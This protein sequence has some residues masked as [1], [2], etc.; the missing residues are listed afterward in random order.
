M[1][2]KYE[3]VIKY[4]LDNYVNGAPALNGVIP[5][6]PALAKE[7][8]M[9][10]CPVNQAINKLVDRGIL[11]KISGVGTFTK[12]YAPRKYGTKKHENMVGTTSFIE[13]F[14]SEILKSLQ[15]KL[16]PE[17]IIINN[18]FDDKNKLESLVQTYTSMKCRG[19]FI[20]PE[21]DFTDNMKRTKVLANRLANKGIIP[22]LV[23]RSVPDYDGVQV[24]VDNTGGTAMAVEYM[25]RSG[26]NKVAYI[27]KD[28]YTVGHDRFKGYLNAL[29]TNNITPD[30]SMIYNDK[31]GINFLENYEKMV[32]DGMTQITKKHPECKCF[33]AFNMA[34][35]FK[36]FLFLKEKDLFDEKI[37]IAG[38]DNFPISPSAEF[39][40]CYIELERPLE[41]IGRVAAS[42]FLEI[43]SLKGNNRLHWI[44]KRILPAMH[45][46]LLN[47]NGFAAKNMRMF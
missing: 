46:P 1:K 31:S 28:D 36:I 14:P 24:T 45:L 15:L 20:I 22:I 16:A 10:R 4:V 40:R 27:G 18:L 38:F 23:E 32:Y 2:Y 8:G 39:E 33:M 43:E 6:E 3:I 41:E 42:T 34:V 21:F 44:H 37:M 17:G 9:S 11:E 13:V 7:L 25:L 19:V 12:G 26:N 29:W 47:N 30:N 35:A 5:S